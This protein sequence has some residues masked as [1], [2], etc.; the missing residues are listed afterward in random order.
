M[1]RRNS[2]F[3]HQLNADF[4]STFIYLRHGQIDGELGRLMKTRI[5]G[6]ALLAIGIPLMIYG[7]LTYTAILGDVGRNNCSL[8]PVSHLPMCED[9]TE[10]GAIF[11]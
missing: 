11:V 5:T 8:N 6:I 1:I 3:K 10:Y 9:A 2:G 4:C 7:V